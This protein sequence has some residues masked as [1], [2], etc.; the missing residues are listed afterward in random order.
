MEINNSINYSIII[1]HKNSP[2][3]LERCLESI[4]IRN[5]IQII[6]V[7]DNSDPEIV[8]F[9]EFP[10]LDRFN[11]EVY[12]TKDSK[13]AG[14]ARNIG[15]SKVI[16]KWIIFADA[17]DF[18]NICLDK[19]MD[20][21]LN[22]NYDIIYFQTNSINNIS[23]KKVESRGIE[24]NK[25]LQD[26]IKKNI[27]LD[28]VRYRINPPWGKFYSNE[29]L[30]KH[31]INFDESL[32]A[33]DVMFSTKSGYAAKNIKIDL[34]YL[35]CSSITIGSL[36]FTNDLEHILPRFNIALKHFEFLKQ[37][38]K[39]KYRINIFNSLNML[40]KLNK[41]NVLKKAFHKAYRVL[42]IKYLILDLLE[43]LKI[44]L[45]NLLWLKRV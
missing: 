14:F 36:D 4:P 38:N 45:R 6:I 41:K 21:Y 5:D 25:W 22:S 23:N 43:I 2:L 42:G 27:I 44:K 26:S 28:E 7:D 9:S 32:T 8:N 1:P 40:R 37:I 13:G 33:N 35:Y 16:G 39:K 34:S 30:K 15:L 10:G 19:K 18:F 24:Y 11:T 12:F 31:N 17:D 29:L 20:E 3:L